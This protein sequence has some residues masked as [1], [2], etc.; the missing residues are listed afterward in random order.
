[1]SDVWGDG[2]LDSLSFSLSLYPVSWS[3]EMR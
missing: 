1:L 3:K 2:G